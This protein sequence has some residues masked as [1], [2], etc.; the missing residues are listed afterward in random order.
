MDELDNW[1]WELEIWK[2][3]TDLEVAKQGPA[4]YLSLPENIC[5]DCA[6]IAVKDLSTDGGMDP[7]VRKLR[8][9]FAKDIDHLAFT[10]Y[11]D[12]KLFKDHWK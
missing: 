8:D 6:D 10:A 9:L 11:E 2:C 12:S 5:H 3:V 7:L 1:I 4:I